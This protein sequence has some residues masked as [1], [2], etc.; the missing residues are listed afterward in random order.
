MGLPDAY[1]VAAS[2][3]DLNIH[4]DRGE[5]C[6]CVTDAADTPMQHAYPLYF[7]AKYP[8]TV[9]R[10]TLWVID[11]SRRQSSVVGIFQTLQILCRNR[12]RKHFV[13]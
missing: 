7:L 2:D 3:F 12:F 11:V 6:G 4:T 9:A 8:R 1:V 13:G 10:W 5:A